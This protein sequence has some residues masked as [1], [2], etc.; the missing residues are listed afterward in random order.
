MKNIKNFLIIALTILVCI[1]CAGQP[2]IQKPQNAHLAI[3]VSSPTDTK[4]EVE[5]VTAEFPCNPLNDED[6]CQLSEM[7]YII[8]DTLYFDLY[9][10]MGVSDIVK[11]KRDILKTEK[12]S[13]I[14][15]AEIWINSGGGSAFTGLAMADEILAAVERGWKIRTK[16]SGI[17]A[18][19][20]VPVF[21]AGTTRIAMPGTIFMVHEPSMFKWPGK[22]TASDIKS[23]NDLMNLLRERYMQ[24]LIYG[25]NIDLSEWQEMERNTTWFKAETARGFGLVT[26]LVEIGIK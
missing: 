10:H 16:A 18:S 3:T 4:L 5:D 1:S 15:D 25:S 6:A 19:A 26:E 7:A 11:M 8:E 20:A 12:Y 9:S 2:Q 14:R 17:V 22:E 21:A 13:N 24:Y 23:Q